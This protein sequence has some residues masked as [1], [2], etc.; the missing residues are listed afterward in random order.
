MLNVNYT[1]APIYSG[2]VLRKNEE[3]LLCS[4]FHSFHNL[5]S[6]ATGNMAVAW[7]EV[8]LPPLGLTSSEETAIHQKSLRGSEGSDEGWGPGSGD[9][10]VV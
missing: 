4:F 1:S 9:T 3:T 6:Q 2:K 7:S 5:L 8:A 10:D